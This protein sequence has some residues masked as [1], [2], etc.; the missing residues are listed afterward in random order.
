MSLTIK[1]LV[2]QKDKF[3]SGEEDDDDSDEAERYDITN[4]EVSL[5]INRLKSLLANFSSS[6]N[7]RIINKIKGVV[8]QTNLMDPQVVLEEFELLFNFALL[9][10]LE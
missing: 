5:V 7:V 2:L 8:M 9:P 4:R 6:M 3:S 1:L 10:I